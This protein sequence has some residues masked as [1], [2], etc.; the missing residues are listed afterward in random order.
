MKY[1]PI[2]Q[3]SKQLLR[4]LASAQ[5]KRG[6]EEGIFILYLWSKT[7]VRQCFTGSCFMSCFFILLHCDVFIAPTCTKQNEGQPS[8]I[9]YVFFSSLLNSQ[10]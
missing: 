8:F 2:N 6:D 7:G 4:N 10:T 5:F 3:S 1:W 9:L